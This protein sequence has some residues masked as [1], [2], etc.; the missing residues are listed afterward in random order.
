MSNGPR[1]FSVKKGCKDGVS[2]I[3]SG[4]DVNP[5]HTN[6]DRFALGFTSDAHDSASCLKGEIVT[7]FIPARSSRTVSRNGTNDGIARKRA[8][9][10]FKRPWFEILNDDISPSNQFDQSIFFL[11]QVHLQ[12]GLSSIAAKEIRS[13]ALTIEIRS[14]RRTPAPCII[15]PRCFDFGDICSQVREHLCCVRP[16]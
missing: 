6:F 8:N 5:C 2:S 10:S 1:S 7:R 15:A 14:K 12:N 16:S 11:F 4:D 9:D 13:D 3:Q